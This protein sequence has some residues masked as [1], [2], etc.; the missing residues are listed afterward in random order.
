[1]AQGYVVAIGGTYQ[2]VPFARRYR[3]PAVGILPST[4]IQSLPLR[5]PLITRVGLVLLHYGM[6]TYFFN[7]RTE[8]HPLSPDTR[9]QRSSWA[10]IKLWYW[11]YKANM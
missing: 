8:F 4:V 1:M 10:L 7:G 9:D 2:S 5:W 6:A 3:L 11:A